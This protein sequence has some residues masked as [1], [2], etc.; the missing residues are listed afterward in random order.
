[1]GF[2]S[3]PRL[4][5]RLRRNNGRNLRLAPLVLALLAILALALALALLAFIILTHPTLHLALFVRGLALGTLS[6]VRVA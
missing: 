5:G 4:Y 3:L 1:M 2:P 6:F